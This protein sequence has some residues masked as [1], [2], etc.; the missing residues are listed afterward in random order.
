MPASR[1]ARRATAS[2]TSDRPGE[3]PAIEALDLLDRLGEIVGRRHRYGTVSI[4]AQMSTA[5]MSAPSSASRTAWPTTLASGRSGDE[6]DL[7]F[8][9][10]HCRF[11]HRYRRI[12]R[13]SPAN[14]LS[15]QDRSGGRRLIET[16]TRRCEWSPDGR[17][18]APPSTVGQCPAAPWP[19]THS[20]SGPSS[21]R[22]GE[23]LRRHATTTARNRTPSTS[24]RSAGLWVTQVGEQL[25]LAPHRREAAQR[26]DVA[27][28]EVV[29]DGERAGVNVT[30]G[31]DQHND[32]TRPANQIQPGH[33]DSRTPPDGRT[34]HRVSTVL[35]VGT[36]QS[37][38]CRCWR[39]SDAAR[40]DV[41]SSPG[42]RNRVR[43]AGR[44]TGRRSP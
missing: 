36:S 2:R 39:P 31:F 13:A 38:S 9:L 20:G 43:P 28:Q 41:G 40:P 16:A 11:S 35:T 21:G 10:S 12:Q 3:D 29:V 4:C 15:S 14:G 5:M 17:G 8:E 34:S 42:G 23:E 26:T 37:Y 18:A 30:H 24:T 6:G 7:A 27:G 1:A 19:F 32:P 25:G 44:R 22:T 33:S